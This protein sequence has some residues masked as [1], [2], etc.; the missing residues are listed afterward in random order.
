MNEQI[1]GVISFLGYR[2]AHFEYDCNPAFRFEDLEG[3]KLQFNFSKA[4]TQIESGETQI[5]LLT[6]VFYNNV[7]NIQ[8]APLRIVVEIAGVFKAAENKPWD[9]KWESNAVAIMYPYV[10]AIIGSL[11][12]QSGRVA[13]ILPTVN[14]AA[15]FEKETQNN[16]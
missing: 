12:S 4:S 14:V 7:D 6:R 13:I 9:T 5:N 16:N 10:R 8:D 11:T 1:S 15:M 3:G 2:L